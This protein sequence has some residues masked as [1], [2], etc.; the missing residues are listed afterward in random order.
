M[1]LIVKGMTNLLK[2]HNDPIM[3]D[4]CS[5]H[6]SLIRTVEVPEGCCLA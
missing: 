1:Q 5:N 6:V 4:A 3:I 2:Q